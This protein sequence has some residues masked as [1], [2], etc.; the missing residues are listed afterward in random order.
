MGIKID[1]ECQ[2]AHVRNFLDCVKSRKRP[3]AEVEIGHRT[4]TACHVGVIAYKLGRTV[5]WDVKS[6]RF[7]NDSEAQAMTTKKYRAPWVLP[8]V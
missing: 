2:I 8:E 6:E 3:A 4:I 1:P 5:R 7:P